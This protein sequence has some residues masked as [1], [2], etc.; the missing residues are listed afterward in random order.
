MALREQLRPYVAQRYADAAATGAPVMRPMF[1]DFWTQ[2]GAAAVDDQLMFGPDYL[3]APQLL[4]QASSRTVWLPQLPATAVWRNEFTGA[5]TDTSAGAVNITEQTPLSGVGFGTFPLYF[6]LPRPAPTAPPTPSTPAGPCGDNCTIT[7][8]LDA[9]KHRLLGHSLSG[10]DAACCATCKAN[11]ACEAFVR[12]PDTRHA[13][14][15]RLHLLPAG[16][17]HELEEIPRPELWL[18]AA[19]GGAAAGSRAEEYH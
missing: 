6:R 7:P 17:R 15:H 18:R 1:F 5:L 12:G 2:P 16:R 10:S 11:P 3:L 14:R 4:Q 19:A 13:G 8:N 9:D